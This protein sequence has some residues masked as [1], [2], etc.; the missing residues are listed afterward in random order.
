M[1]PQDGLVRRTVRVM[2][3]VASNPEGVGLTEVSR[4]T[5]LS[6][7]TVLRILNDLVA[8][9]WVAANSDTHKYRVS[10]GM[11]DVVGRLLDGNSAFE[12]LRRAL[13]YLSDETQETAGFDLLVRPHVVVVAQEA[14]PQLISQANRPVPRSQPVWVTATGR[15][16][17]AYEDSL[18]IPKLYGATFPAA[19]SRERTQGI[20]DFI[21]ELEE[22][23]QR[24]YAFVRDKLEDGA[25][26]IGAPVF[27]DGRVAY[28][29]WIGGPTFR[30][31]D[32]RIP[33]L[34]AQLVRA[35]NELSALVQVG[36]IQFVTQ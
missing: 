23:R 26:A 17:L 3:A 35:A 27:N 29:L 34:A 18:S 30:F 5:D 15:V 6:K 19:T 32:Q 28:A 1:E 4:L 21:D 8:E 13:R 31:T 9:G 36:E 24:G 22:V 12:H 11:L 25:S 14:G 10:L 20:K 2:R 16:F 33:E 7:A